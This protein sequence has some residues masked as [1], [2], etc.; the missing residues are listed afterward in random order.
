MFS[1]LEI[2]GGVGAYF[3]TQDEIARFV[4]VITQEELTRDPNDFVAQ[5]LRQVA[6]SVSLSTQ[7]FAAVYLLSHGV[8]KTIL[9]VGLYR[10]KLNFYPL[11]IVL[12][13]AFVAY[14]LFR[15]HV[16]HS[17]WLLVLT[18]FDLLIIGLTLQEYRYLRRRMTTRPTAPAV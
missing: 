13:A 4:T 2:V 12:F 10:E 7:H 11:S 5:Y 1:V 16:T 14:Q 15:F 9:I 17:V 6:S 8:L 3:I 18:A